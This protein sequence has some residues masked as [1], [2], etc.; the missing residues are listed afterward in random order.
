MFENVENVGDCC[1]YVE[2]VG[3]CC[4]PLEVG[5][6]TQAGC[7]PLLVVSNLLVLGVCHRDM[8][9]SPL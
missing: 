9:L 4:E 6:A 2:N 7:K 5:R 1:E 3:V 8:L